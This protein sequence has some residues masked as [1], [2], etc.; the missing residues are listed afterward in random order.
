[1]RAR[2][3]EGGAGLVRV[4]VQAPAEGGGGVRRVVSVG[5]VQK[6]GNKKRMLT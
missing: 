3:D 4:P 5:G 1:M 2:V 6:W